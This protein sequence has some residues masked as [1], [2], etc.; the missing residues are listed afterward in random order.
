MA[1]FGFFVLM[2]GGETGLKLCPP[3]RENAM[4]IRIFRT[5]NFAHRPTP[6]TRA[7]RSFARSA[8]HS[9]TF[10]KSVQV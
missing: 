6:R 8:S 1:M 9:S 3:R 2:L 4:R 10:P 5:E 7:C